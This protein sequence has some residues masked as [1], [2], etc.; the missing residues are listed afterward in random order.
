MIL[1]NTE[2]YAQVQVC[3]FCVSHLQV[4]ACL[5]KSFNLSYIKIQLAILSHYQT[6]WV[7]F[8][9]KTVFLSVEDLL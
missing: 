6:T 3:V 1:C 7:T 8:P 4:F 5:E 2:G 9:A